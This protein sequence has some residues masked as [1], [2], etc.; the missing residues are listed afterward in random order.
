MS[1]GTVNKV[2]L[3]GRVGNMPEIISPN[4]LDIAKFSVATNDGYKNKTGEY[5]ENTEWHKIVV[6][7]KIASTLMPYV[8]KGTLI[9]IEGST[10]T[11]KWQNKEGEDKYSTEVIARNIEILRKNTSTQSERP[12]DLF[13]W[14]NM[15]IQ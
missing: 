15:N 12:Q 11:N 7:G 4:G 6:F 8:N 3:I 13:E 1:Q 9:Y 14:L 5:I 10:K 2:I